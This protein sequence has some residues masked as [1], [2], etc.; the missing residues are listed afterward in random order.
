MGEARQRDEQRRCSPV[1]W[2]LL[3]TGYSLA[4]ESAAGFPALEEEW[5]V[6]QGTRTVLRLLTRCAAEVQPFPSAGP[7]CSPFSVGHLLET[8]FMDFGSH[9]VII[10]M[11]KEEEEE[12]L[13][14]LFW[15]ELGT[16]S[17]SL[18]P[19]VPLGVSPSVCGSQSS[20]FH[21]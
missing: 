14:G 18:S 20:R 17:F 3:T 6:S 11:Q 19:W 10:L 1:P 13:R 21:K 4:W 15:V 9:W 5:K 12:E 16:N 7:R 8:S 2:N